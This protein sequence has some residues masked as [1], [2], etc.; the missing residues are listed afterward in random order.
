MQVYVRERMGEG[1]GE[2]GGAKGRN[3]GDWIFQ[4][5]Q[6]GKRSVLLRFRNEID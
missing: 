5:E 6:P 4:L 2:R 3:M 1:G